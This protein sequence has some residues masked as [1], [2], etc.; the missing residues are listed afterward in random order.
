MASRNSEPRCLEAAAT[1]SMLLFAGTATL[2]VL[3]RTGVIDVKEV[4]RDMTGEVMGSFDTKIPST[5]L[6][7]YLD[8]RWQRALKEGGTICAA[9]DK[10]TEG[11]ALE[12]HSQAAQDEMSDR[13]QVNVWLDTWMMCDDKELYDTQLGF[14][15]G[16]P[17]NKTTCVQESSGSDLSRWTCDSLFGDRVEI[18][19][20][21][22]SLIESGLVH[23][24]VPAELEL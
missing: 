4:T 17:Y 9:Q 2:A 11:V 12:T 6:T 7:S 22:S 16:P 10:Y 24:E 23:E 19:T 15:W 8:L 5:E 20:T 21:G 13:G 14:T 18:E 3:D 1:A